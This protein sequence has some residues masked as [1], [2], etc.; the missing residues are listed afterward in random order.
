MGGPDR[1]EHTFSEYRRGVG[2]ERQNKMWS[3]VRWTV[4]SESGAQ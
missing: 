4:P 1:M 3:L 2:H